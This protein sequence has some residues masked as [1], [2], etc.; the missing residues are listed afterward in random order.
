M[1]HRQ[2]EHIEERMQERYMG[3]MRHLI[4]HADTVSA[5]M[6]FWRESAQRNEDMLKAAQE[7]IQRQSAI[8]GNGSCDAGGTSGSEH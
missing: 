4:A 3:E 7:L 6:N 5:D 1:V 8:A 2:I